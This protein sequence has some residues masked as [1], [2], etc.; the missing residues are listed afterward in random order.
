MK[1][2]TI[3]LVCFLIITNGF[4]QDID[5]MLC[6]SEG[7]KPFWILRFDIIDSETHYPIDDAIINITSESGKEL[8]WPAHQDG[9][10]I[11]I[12][13][14]PNCIPVDGQIEITSPRY[15]FY[16]KPIRRN[17]FKTEKDDRM[18]YLEG[19]NQNWT[20]LNQLP[21]TQEIFDKIRDKRYRVGVK[22]INSEFGFRVANFAPACFEYS[23]EMERINGED[24]YSDHSPYNR[25]P[26][27][28]NSNLRGFQI[29]SITYN[30][31]TIYVFPN[32]LTNGPYHWDQAKNACS[33]LN[34]LGYDDWYLPSKEELNVLYINKDKIG[35]FNGWYWS[36]T[37]SS[38][39]NA[40][41]QNFKYGTQ[42]TIY[43]GT[44]YNIHKGNIKVRCIRKE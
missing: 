40:W 29:P 24:F 14:D 17:Y 6:G 19:Y 36:A 9:F 2:L 22:E 4:C 11:L 12:V 23:V 1:R 31:E 30:G 13:T 8:K 44:T 5:G 32:D 15:R 43:K 37:E 28:N 7:E 38:S 16:Q 10:S 42:E 33:L 34:R 41:I 27:K 3:F 25:V 20:D 26:Q 18:I 21:E 39:R 35:E